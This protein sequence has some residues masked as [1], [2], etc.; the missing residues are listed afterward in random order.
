[1]R[2]RYKI[3][4]KEGVFFITSSIVNWIP[5]FKSRK[6]SDILIE[7]LKFYQINNGLIIYAYVIMPDHF[8]LIGSNDELTKTIQSFKKYTAKE[9]ITNLKR[10]NNLSIL[11]EFRDEKLSYKTS[12]EFQVWQEGFH[13]QEMLNNEILKQKIEYI[14]YNPVRNALVEKA[15]DWLYSSAKDYS[16]EDNGLINIKRIV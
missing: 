5:I 11:N 16:I 14:H 9:I 4:N 15:E 1:M 10:D 2:S 12:S 13:P 8:H 6:Y 3:Y 7:N